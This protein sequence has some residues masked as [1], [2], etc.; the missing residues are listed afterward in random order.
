MDYL[1]LCLWALGLGFSAWAAAQPQEV[2]P[3]RWQNVERVVVV[4]DVHGALQPLLSVL[5]AAELID[6]EQRWTGG[7]THLVSVGD[8]IDRGAGSR[9]VLDLMR[10]LQ[11]QAAAAGGRVHVLLGNHEVMNLTADLR[12]VS[13]PEMASYGGPAGHRQ[14][15]SS[16]GVYGSWLLSLP[17]MLII[18]NSLFVHGGLSTA[19]AGLDQQQVNERVGTALTALRA[20]AAAARA[21]HAE[22]TADAESPG[23]DMDLLT[24]A[25]TLGGLAAEGAELPADIAAFVAAA[26]EPLLGSFG[27]HWHRGNAACHALLESPSLRG[28]LQQFAVE[29]VIVG[30]TPTPGRK[31]RSRLDGQVVVVDTGMLAEVYKGKPFV[32]EITGSRI[33]VI[34]S[35]AQRT[36]ALTA[37]PTAAQVDALRNMLTNEDPQLGEQADGVTQLRF[38]D[39]T[40][41]EFEIMPQKQAQRVLAAYRLDRLLGLNMMAETVSRKVS[42]KTGVVRL[43]DARWLSE[44][45]RLQ[46]GYRRPNYCR[47][48]SDYDLLSAFDTLTG[49]RD[50]SGENLFYRL[51]TWEIR[52]TGQQRAFPTDSRP[53]Q[54]AHTPKLAPAL[55]EKLA[56]LDEA[57][58]QAELE[59]LLSKRQIKAILKRRDLVQGWPEA[60]E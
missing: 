44:Q 24:L 36:E 34:D 37:Q 10:S 53:N 29:R 11:N 59:D 20:V 38:K 25:D 6:A 47:Q 58:L 18:D 39:G 19:L 8:L 30:H 21:Y 16:A 49:Q 43:K 1:K 40:E 54:Y 4:G 23:S 42:G 46:G 52:A 2:A 60:A 26:A 14:L 33:A 3:G 13:E 22:I 35:Q 50:R 27:P 48:G 12:D 31:V 32:L 15:F 5:S 51:P 56:A 17:T 28:L 55:A 45:Q 57:R 9:A 41:A 7:A